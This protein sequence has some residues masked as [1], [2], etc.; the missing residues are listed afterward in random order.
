[1]TRREAS[2]YT[3]GRHFNE[4]G[5]RRQI[6]VIQTC[7]PSG[8]STIAFRA[9]A[10]RN[11]CYDVRYTSSARGH[12]VL[13]DDEISWKSKLRV[14]YEWSL[15][16]KPSVF[17]LLRII[18]SFKPIRAHETQDASNVSQIRFEWTDVYA[19]LLIC[20][21]RLLWT[22]ADS[23]PAAVIRLILPTSYIWLLLIVVWVTNCECVLSFMS[24]EASQ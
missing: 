16:N 2:D 22:K 3:D 19:Y 13:V 5:P 23:C 18:F 9:F 24:Y 21:A 7:F 17:W 4:L 6:S 20:W 10:V 12:A 14:E 11:Y 15:V 8:S 1:M